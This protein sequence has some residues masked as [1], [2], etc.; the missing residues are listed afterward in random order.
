MMRLLNWKDVPVSIPKGT[1]VATMEH[2]PDEQVQGQV[3]GQVEE[4]QDVPDG[5]QDRLWAMVERA[6]SQL[7]PTQMKE[8]YAVLLEYH[9][10]FAQ[11]PTDFGRTGVIK[12]D[13]DTGEAK[14]IRQQ[15]R[16]IPPYKRDEAKKLLQEMLE[17]DV[18]QPSSS[19]WASP[20]VL[21][22]KKDGSTRF[23]IDYR[24][25]NTVTRKDAYPMPRVDD[26]LDTLAGAKWFSTL[27][28]ISGYWQVEVNP[29]DREKTAFCT[30]EG[31]FEFKVMPFGLCNAPATFQRLMDMVL[32]G[33][34]W[35][36]CL[37]YI[38]DV[39]ILGK[40]FK[41]H[42][43]N[44]VA[45]FKRLRSSS[46][47]LKP[48][49]CNFCSAE[50]DF[51]GHI[52][53]ANG[54]RT[55]PSKTMQVSQWPIPTSR[56][57]VQQFLGLANYYQRFVKDFAT[58]AKPL[59]RLT[60]RNVQFGWSKESH[61]AFEL[62]RKRLTTAPVLAF[63]DYSREFILDTDASDTGLGAVLSQIQDDG[64]E[65]VISYASRVL[66]RAER[67]FCVTRRE[68]LAVVTFVQHFRPYL[69]GR[70]FLLRTDHGSLTWLSN[71]KQPEGQLARWLER[72]QEFH[73]RIQ[74]RPGKKH[75]NADALSRR[76]CSQCGRDNHD[77]D[78][79]EKIE[80][81]QQEI[82][83]TL[84]EKTPAEIRQLQ[85]DDKPIGLLLEAVEKGIKPKLAEVK[86]LGPVAQRLLHC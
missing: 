22:Q 40:T 44:L 25:V 37:V 82:N 81:V 20:I 59:H 3:Q 48:K 80:A 66:S 73:L 31:L 86:T 57:E 8:L 16:R 60:E 21:V 51:L 52:V 85:L 35:T 4:Q 34:Q 41:E 69:L 29:K 12:H 23:C 72:L 24:K 53:S 75:Q 17:K 84:S 55:D 47:K 83:S 10:L 79:P 50:V 11:G 61:T 38:D 33:V 39:V 68:L 67:R 18:I 56:K 64:S 27:D 49:K 32:A 9:D 74:H 36:S 54:V 26:T 28:L 30:P 63:P 62:L 77:S 7:T 2:L 15:V 70:E 42:L 43:Q 19:P 5:V 45:V 58:I 1:T 71:F 13:I 6:G 46:L 65:R 14:P 76:P 78:M